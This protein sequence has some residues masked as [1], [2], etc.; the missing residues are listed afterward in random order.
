V[1]D[2]ARVC[3]SAWA[4]RLSGGPAGVAFGGA[5]DVPRLCVRRVV[6]VAGA[7]STEGV[8]TRGCKQTT[9][10]SRSGGVG[11]PRKVG[12]VGGCG[13]GG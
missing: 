11:T 5:G 4:S 1:G 7:V 10:R 3:A 2:Q 8:G 6:G 12:G 13:E 9:D